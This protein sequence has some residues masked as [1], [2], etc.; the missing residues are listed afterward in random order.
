MLQNDIG[1]MG[2]GGIMMKSNAL[3]V[4]PQWMVLGFFWIGLAGASGVRL[5]AVIGRYDAEAALWVWRGAMFCYVLFFGYRVWI[6]RRRRS[7]IIRRN[8]IEKLSHAHFAD[9]YDQ[10]AAQYVLRSI[11]RSKELFNYTFIWGLSIAALLIDL[12]WP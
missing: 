3:P 6:G 1:H 4:V 8:L 12:F 10:Q 11:V 2:S 9:P 5:L 7:L